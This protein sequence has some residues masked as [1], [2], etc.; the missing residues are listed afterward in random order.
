V[1]LQ[2]RHVD[3]FVQR[4][5]N[6]WPLK[7]TQWTKFY[8]DLDALTLD[9]VPSNS[10]SDMSYDPTGEGIRF[11]SKP[12]DMDTEITGP[13]AAKIFASSESEDADLFLA[14]HLIDPDG[15][16]IT[17]QGSN[18]PHTPIGLGWLRAS[19]R[20]LDDELSLPHRPYHTHDEIWPLTPGKAEELDIEIW[21]TCIVVPKG[22]QIALTI[23]GNDYR[24]DG[25][26]IKIPGIGYEMFG[27]G[28]FVHT[29]PKDRPTEIFNAKVR[30]VADVTHQP[31][32]LLPIVPKKE[33]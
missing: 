19:H 31:Y 26:T 15:K 30:L 4:A 7:R 33:V 2:V 32:L 16:E 13:L 23:K 24:Y 1:Q 12:F 22:Y 6:E 14:F 18:D 21:P 11:I 3:K 8:L 25:P 5:E 20:K 28:P 29:H 17:F 10:S 9:Q 27:V